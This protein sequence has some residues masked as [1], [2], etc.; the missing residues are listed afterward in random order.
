MDSRD[1]GNGQDP[2]TPEAGQ[3]VIEAV[4]AEIRLAKQDGAKV[5]DLFVKRNPTAKVDPFHERERPLLQRAVEAEGV[6]FVPANLPD[7]SFYHDEY[8]PSPKGNKAIADQLA[9][10]LR[11]A[12]AEGR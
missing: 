12:I 7:R 2:E 10:V 3:A 4:R 8:H 6:Q 11:N 5:T 1:P 9:P